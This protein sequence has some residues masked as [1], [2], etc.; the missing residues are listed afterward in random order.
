MNI[1]NFITYKEEYDFIDILYKNGVYVN[2]KYKF[3]KYPKSNNESYIV[4]WQIIIRTLKKYVRSKKGIFYRKHIKHIK[5]INHELVNLPKK[6]IRNS[7]PI[8]ISPNDFININKSHIYI[9][10]KTDGI[11]TNITPSNIYPSFYETETLN[12]DN[13]VCEYIKKYNLYLVFS[14]KK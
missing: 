2:S 1:D 13:F 8:H 11:N 3:R 4:K 6:I 5:S 7:N 10:Q 9:S 14:S 12:S